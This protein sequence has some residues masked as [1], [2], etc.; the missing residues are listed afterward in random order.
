[1]YSVG[2]SI[3]LANKLPGILNINCQISF[4]KLT[5]NF[6]GSGIRD[7]HVLAE[8]FEANLISIINWCTEQ[9]ETQKTVS[10]FSDSS[11]SVEELEEF[12]QLFE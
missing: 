5:V 2:S 1:M 8:H 6:E 10:D 7:I 9:R 4:G 3:S 11:L 12:S